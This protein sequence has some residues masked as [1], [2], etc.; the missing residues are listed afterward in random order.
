[1]GSTMRKRAILALL[2]MALVASAANQTQ[3]KATTAI[4]PDHA[5]WV[6]AAENGFGLTQQTFQDAGLAKL[7]TTEYGA[8]LI[9]MQ[10]QQIKTAE[11]AKK[12]VISYDCGGLPEAKSKIKIV[13]DSNSDAPSEIMSPLRQRLRGMSDVEIV[14]DAQH[15][16]FGMTALVMPVE[17]V[18]HYKTGYAASIVTYEGCQAKLGDTKWP[19]RVMN[20]HWVFT[21][22]TDASQIVND[23]VTS[24]D[25]GDIEQARKLRSALNSPA[26]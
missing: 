22:G 1:M 18:N 2:L 14:F 20:N 12:S 11:D 16:D 5:V 23:I 9:A 4:P 25:T 26:K 19:I 6:P 8:L 21:A 17:S 10:V 3:R 24:I 13:V 7:T 15:A